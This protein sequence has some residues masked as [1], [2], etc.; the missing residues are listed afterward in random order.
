MGGF[1]AIAAS[2]YFNPSLTIYDP[3]VATRCVYI[4]I[5][6]VHKGKGKA[7]PLQ[8]YGAQRVVGR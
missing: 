8:T 2:A 5:Q 6:Y 7:F 3:F 4:Y 1:S